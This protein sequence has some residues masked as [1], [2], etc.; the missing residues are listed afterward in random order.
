MQ[1]LGG[2]A[3]LAKEITRVILAREAERSILI[4]PFCGGCSITEQLA[5]HFACTLASDAHPD[6]V[7]MWDAVRQGWLPPEELPEETYRALRSAAPC[8]LRG[9]AGFAC[10]FSGKW[11]GGYA[12]C[13]RGDDYTAAGRNSLKRKAPVLQSCVL[14]CHEYDCAPIIPGA[15]MYLD[16]PYASTT[17]YS[18]EFN[19]AKFW[20]WAGRCRAAGA[21]V[22]VSEYEAPDGW[23]CIW[24]RSYARNMRGADGVATACDRLYV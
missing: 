11:F 15:V 16:P 21:R 24:Q 20:Q 1:Y 23:E 12:R 5:P 2:K 8:P 19:S 4:E 13:N 22:Y 7:M 17:G 10:S 9:F 14:T 18:V 6:L 3:K